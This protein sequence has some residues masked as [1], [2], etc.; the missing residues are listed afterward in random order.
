MPIFDRNIVRALSEQKG[1]KPSKNL[2]DASRQL[3]TNHPE[4]RQIQ[5]LTEQLLAD[6]VPL[7]GFSLSLSL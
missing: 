6:R 4:I 7:S 1:S 2:P 3:L 5:G